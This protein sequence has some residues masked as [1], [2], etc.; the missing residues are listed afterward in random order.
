MLVS[1]RASDVRV[2]NQV[3]SLIILRFAIRREQIL[4]RRQ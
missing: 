1:S 3:S 4:K 2:G